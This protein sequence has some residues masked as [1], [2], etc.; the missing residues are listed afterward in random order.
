MVLKDSCSATRGNTTHARARPAGLPAGL[1]GGQAQHRG[2]ARMSVEQREPV[3]DGSV[4]CGRG[5]FVE[6]DFGGESRYAKSPPSATIAPAPD[7]GIGGVQL[8]LQVGHRVGKIGRAFDRG[9]VDAVLTIT[10]SEGG[11]GDDGLADDALRPR[12]RPAARSS[13]ARMRCR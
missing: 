7:L 12:Q 5:Q 9:R 8:D 2:M 10:D 11:A 1:V 3:V 4:P 13:A 6:E